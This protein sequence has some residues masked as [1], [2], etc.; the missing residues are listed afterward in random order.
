MHRGSSCGAVGV[1][2]SLSLAS[3]SARPRCASVRRLVPAGFATQRVSAGDVCRGAAC[4]I[5]FSA[6]GSALVS[7][8]GLLVDWL[9]DLWS[10]ASSVRAGPPSAMGE[11]VS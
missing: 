6:G 9:E 2:P 11:P 10:R 3:L 8:S 4:L 1:L 5:R 7:R